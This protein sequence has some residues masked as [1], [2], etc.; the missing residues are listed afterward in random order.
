MD[1]SSHEAEYVAVSYGACQAFWMKMLLQELK[2]IEALKINLLVNNR[3]A[4]DLTNHQMSYGR[5]K[6][7]ERKW[8]LLRDRVNKNKLEIEYCKS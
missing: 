6:Y 2:F 3:Y 5:S 4:V 7:I 8:N 1:L